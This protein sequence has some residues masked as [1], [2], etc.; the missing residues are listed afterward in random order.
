MPISGNLN[1]Q[2]FIAHFCWNVGILKYWNIGFKIGMGLFLNFQIGCH[3]I[4]KNPFIH[5]SIIPL[6]QYQ[7]SARIMYGYFLTTLITFNDQRRK[8]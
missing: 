7:D 2:V 1:K 5:H 3:P 6:F 4:K 8:I